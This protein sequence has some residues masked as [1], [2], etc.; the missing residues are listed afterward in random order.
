MLFLLFICIQTFYPVSSGLKCFTYRGARTCIR[1]GNNCT[2]SNNKTRTQTERKIQCAPQKINI[3]RPIITGL[4]TCPCGVLNSGQRW[5]EAEQRQFMALKLHEIFNKSSAPKG[6]WKVIMT[7]LW[8]LKSQSSVLRLYLHRQKHRSFHTGLVRATYNLLQS[9]TTF[10]IN[11]HPLLCLVRTNYNLLYKCTSPYSVFP[12]PLW[13]STWL[14]CL[15]GDGEDE[16]HWAWK[17]FVLPFGFGFAP[18]LYD[19]DIQKLRKFDTNEIRAYF[20]P[21]GFPSQFVFFKNF[22]IQV[23]I[24]LDLANQRRVFHTSDS[25]NYFGLCHR[26]NYIM[27][28]WI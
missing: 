6:G 7:L 11:V 16:G 24:L 17:I 21:L 15:P 28:P 1:V 9:T 12:R 14:S 10:S 4:G 2:S 8:K 23:T 26:S 5:T 27:I 20:Y 18:Q 3:H 25:F 13:W 22:F 19:L